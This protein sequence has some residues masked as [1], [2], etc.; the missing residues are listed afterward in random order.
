MK[1]KIVSFVRAWTPSKK[2][3]G[4]FLQVPPSATNIESSDGDDVEMQLD[5]SAEEKEFEKIMSSEE[6]YDSTSDE[7][8]S[9]DPSFDIEE[10][11]DDILENVEVE[12]YSPTSTL[13]KA[14]SQPRKEKE[15][16]KDAETHS[17]PRYGSNTIG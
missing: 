3:R 1:M 14:F 12:T 17:T 7:D 4:S 6:M 16:S 5:E 2:T 13:S 10:E 8:F 15:V 11:V 9:R